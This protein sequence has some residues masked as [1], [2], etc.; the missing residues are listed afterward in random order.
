MKFTELEIPGV[1]L[2]EPKVYEDSRGA[3]FEFYQKE[4]FQANG[5][6]TNFV[7]D[8]LSV[9]AKGTLRGLHFQAEPKSQA[10]LVMVVSGEVFDVAV[11]LRK[12]SKTFGKHVAV[13]LS[14][15]NRK[16]FFVPAGFAHG[17]CALTEGTKFLYK[18]SEYYSPEH[19]RGIF[20]RDP[21]LEIKWPK[22]DTPYL[23]NERDQKF[24]P[25]QA[26]TSK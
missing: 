6:Q 19:E 23:L 7:Q 15:Q 12:N 5:I 1:F 2:I 21:A 18:V 13:Y 22:L 3:F 4:L 20:W 11:D 9:S 16:L 25:L 26:F 8:N 24:P 14:A 10:K 17:F